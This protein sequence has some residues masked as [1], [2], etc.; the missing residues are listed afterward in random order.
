MYN[1]LFY[2]LMYNSQLKYF[3]TKKGLKANR[4]A[5]WQNKNILHPDLH[6]FYDTVYL[7][8]THCDNCGHNFSIYR[9]TLD[10]DHTTGLI[11]QILCSSCNI[12]DCFLN[13]KIEDGI[14]LFRYD[15]PRIVIDGITYKLL[16]NG[17]YDFEN[18]Q[19]E[20]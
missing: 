16:K 7:P 1:D 13:F 4:I 5:Q 15:E 20:K 19:A 9:K 8:A 18:G 17:E 3:K 12:K 10:H 2:N 11:R 6:L 14:K